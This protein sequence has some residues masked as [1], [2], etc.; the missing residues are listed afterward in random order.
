MR[1]P[2]TSMILS[3]LLALSWIG[4]LASQPQAEERR[5]LNDKWDYKSTDKNSELFESGRNGWEAYAV[6]HSTGDTQPTYFLKKRTN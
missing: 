6:I 5:Y 2:S 3:A 4:F 1:K